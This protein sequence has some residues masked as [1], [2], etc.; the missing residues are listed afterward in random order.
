MQRIRAILQELGKQVGIIFIALIIEYKTGIFQALS[1]DRH[2]KA[3]PSLLFQIIWTL[4]ISIASINSMRYMWKW[5]AIRSFS[6]RHIREEYSL[7]AALMLIS[8]TALV[9]C[10]TISGIMVWNLPKIILHYYYSKIYYQSDTRWTDFGFMWTAYVLLLT[11]TFSWHKWWSGKI[12]IEHYKSSQIGENPSLIQE[13][14]DMIRRHVRGLPLPTA[15]TKEPRKLFVRVLDTVSDSLAWRDQARELLE[16][17]CLSYQFEAENAWH[18]SAKCWV[19]TNTDNQG[20]IL[21]Y[22]VY[23]ADEFRL[24]A[25]NAKLYAHYLVKQSSST[26]VTKTHIYIITR[27]LTTKI[28]LP[29]PEEDEHTV[30]RYIDEEA[31]LDRMVNFSDYKYEIRRRVVINKIPELDISLSDTYTIPNFYLPDIDKDANFVYVDNEEATDCIPAETTNF[32]TKQTPVQEN[33]ELYLLKWLSTNDRKHIAILGEYGQG[34]S[35][36]ALMLTYKLL[37]ERI[38]M[39]KI[40]ILIE[41]RGTSPRNMTPIQLLGAWASRYKIQPQALMK[42]LIAGRLILIFEGFDEMALVGDAEMRLNHFRT[43]WRFSYPN[44]KILITGR[45]NFFFD[46][47][48]M[49]IALGMSNSEYSQGP[50]CQVIRIAPFTTQ[51]AEHA[52]RRFSPNLR[53]QIIETAHTNATFLDLISRPALLSIVASLWEKEK[54]SGRVSQLTS[55]YIIG[56]FVRKSYLRQG[57]KETD[58]PEFMALNSQ[59]REYFMCGIASYMAYYGMPNQIDSVHLGEAIERLLENFP[60]SISSQTPATRGEVSAPLRVRIQAAEF[61]LEHLKTDVRACG[62]LVDEP[63]SPDTFRFGHKSFLEYLIAYVVAEILKKT[64]SEEIRAISAAT[65]IHIDDIFSYPES[66]DFL[67][68]LVSSAYRGGPLSNHFSGMPELL[69]GICGSRSWPSWVVQRIEIFFSVLII[70]RMK[71]LLLMKN[72]DWRKQDGLAATN[73]MPNHFLNTAFQTQTRRLMVYSATVMSVLLSIFKI[74]SYLKDNHSITI[75]NSYWG[76]ATGLLPIAASLVAFFFLI[77]GM[78]RSGIISSQ[79]ERIKLYCI[80]AVKHRISAEIILATLMPGLGKR[81]KSRFEARKIIWN[82]CFPYLS[83]SYLRNARGGLKN[84]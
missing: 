35:T 36:I 9:V 20:M 26:S 54:L 22:P 3:S 59:E 83:E 39:G 31:L 37:F 6:Q 74:T 71:D 65:R 76:Q 81:I 48:E 70:S 2:S 1:E 23:G 10:S 12:S 43:L 14:F 45:P 60:D 80:I 67:A 19:G 42:L 41:L 32:K 73:I 62:L 24:T 55:A 40:P 78:L 82:I 63:G 15:H 52:L 66:V 5:L 29:P 72:P 34:K 61:G 28:Q 68:E 64:H 49:R 84:S 53:K 4:L 38:D 11:L 51:Q 77:M 46:D 57:Q 50:T 17:T 21:V 69:R 30:I 79:L 56:L 47:Q 25:Q 44:A 58:S 16:L 8:I 13:S 7:N 75:E 27:M 18:D 33:L